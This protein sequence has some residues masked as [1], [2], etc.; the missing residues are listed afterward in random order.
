MPP[1]TP[2][3][4]LTDLPEPLFSR[5]LEALKLN[6]SQNSLIR[7]F[8]QKGFLVIQ[9]EIDL[10]TIEAAIEAT[11]VACVSSEGKILE[12]RVMD[13]WRKNASIK[14]IAAA[15]K[16]M[17]VLRLLYQRRPIPFQTLNFPIGTEQKTHSD[18]IHF[19][20]Y[21]RG[22]M[23]GVWVA[24]E[25][26]DS[27]N[28][29]LHYYEGSHRLPVYEMFDIGREGRAI[30]HSSQPEHYGYYESFIESFIDHQGFAKKELHLKKGEA[31]I[32]ASNLFHGGNP[33]KNPSRTR[34]SQVTHYYFENCMYYTPLT[35]DPYPGKIQLKPLIDIATGESISNQFN[36]KPV[37]IY[38]GQDFVS[39]FKQLG[40]ILRSRF[41]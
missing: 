16:I 35:C 15:P 21:P 40:R 39:G 3:I 24:F 38:L 37:S 12:R 31:L 6:D 14:A 13:A 8:A 27:E 23:C 33:I 7:E 36:G 5:A 19:N 32:W 29:A 22:F 18:T 28:G 41:R 25:D 34:F 10:K 17:E 11:K 20:C 30:Q 1:I 4:P 26:T 2:N 9:P